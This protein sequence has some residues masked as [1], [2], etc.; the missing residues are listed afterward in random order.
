MYDAEYKGRW[1]KYIS[2]R[3]TDFRRSRSNS[4]KRTVVGRRL[5]IIQT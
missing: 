4:V 3:T 2:F 1:S 5:R